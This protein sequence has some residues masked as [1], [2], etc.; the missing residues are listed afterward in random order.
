MRT[1]PPAAIT[2]ARSRAYLACAAFITTLLIAL[3]ADPMRANALFSFKNSGLI[4]L[5]AL[6]VVLTVL[7]LWWDVLRQPRVQSLQYSLGLWTASTAGA[8]QHGTLQVH[9]DLQTYILARWT[10]DGLS[11]Q[12]HQ[13]SGEAMKE[14]HDFTNKLFR[15]RVSSGAP[16]AWLHIERHMAA[17]DSDWLALRRALFAA[18]HGRALVQPVSIPDDMINSGTAGH[19]QPP[20][21][22]H[23]PR[24]S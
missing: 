21:H 18:R 22:E 11:A 17:S 3:C 1:A 24:S 13:T 10:G 2:L 14:P 19:G 20:P 16:T 12:A 4:A 5:S 15:W 23:P 7:W 9:L 8:P 6:T